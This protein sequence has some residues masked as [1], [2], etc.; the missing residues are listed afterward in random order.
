[1]KS[2]FSKELQKRV[3]TFSW[4]LVRWTCFT[5]TTGR[6]GPQLLIFFYRSLKIECD[7]EVKICI[8]CITRPLNSVINRF[9]IINGVALLFFKFYEGVF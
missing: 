7:F 6:F 4:F 3:I 2:D 9:N 8:V 1:L 5:W